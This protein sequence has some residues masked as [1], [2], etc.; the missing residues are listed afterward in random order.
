M[1]ARA[2]QLVL[3]LVFLS[4]LPLGRF[5]PPQV[6][7][8]GAVVWAFPLAGAILGALAALPLWWLGPGLLPAALSLALLVWL[9]G[10]LHEDALADFADA[11]GGRST[12]ERFRIMRDSTI[13]A[14]GASALL[15]CYGLRLAALSMLGP[16]ALVASAAAGRAGAVGLMRALPPA[17]R[18]GLGHDA[19]R[20]R[21]SALLVAIALAAVLA[22]AVL[23]LLPALA[24]LVAAGVAAMAVARRAQRLLGGQT[25]DVLGAGI[26]LAETAALVALALAG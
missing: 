26:I 14:Y 16:L 3:A 17:R 21:A 22:L 8:L 13:G 24:A 1:R 12:E 9:T 2:Q 6:L 7:P 20:P 10:A 5:L 19:G 15:A 25:G 4:R 23:P 11:G 18:D